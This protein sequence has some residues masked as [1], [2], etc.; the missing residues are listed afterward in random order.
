M[1]I[2]TKKSYLQIKKP[3]KFRGI[4]PFSCYSPFLK[5]CEKLFFSDRDQP[6]VRND[7]RKSRL[8]PRDYAFVILVCNKNSPFFLQPTSENAEN[9]LT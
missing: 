9:T 6:V 3:N 2:K 5:T 1:K 7:L 4:F 8:V